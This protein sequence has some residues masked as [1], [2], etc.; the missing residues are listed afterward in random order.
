[1][2]TVT[3]GNAWFKI[4]LFCGPFN[5]V[6]LY[7]ENDWCCPDSPPS[8]AKESKIRGAVFYHSL[9][10]QYPSN[11]WLSQAIKRKSWFSKICT[12]WFEVLLQPHSVE[13]RYYVLL[14]CLPLEINPN[15]VHQASCAF[16]KGQQMRKYRQKSH[17]EANNKEKCNRTLNQI[18]QLKKLKL[19]FCGLESPF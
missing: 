17:E 1:M 4:I 13:N 10:V 7:Q 15:D 2:L 3:L 12:F 9:W 11:N 18:R 5:F 19:G 16:I 14:L 6:E 8:M